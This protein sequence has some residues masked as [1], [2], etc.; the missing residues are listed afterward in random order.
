MATTTP[1][2]YCAPPTSFGRLGLRNLRRGVL[3]ADLALLLVFCWLAHPSWQGGQV[4]AQSA[5]RRAVPAGAPAFDLR[6]TAVP[7]QEIRGGGPPKDGI[8]AITDPAMIEA[9]R[10]R[11]LRP[12]DRVIGMVLR[13]ERN[14]QEAR[15]YPIKILTQHEIV[16]DRIGDT[17]IGV[18]YCPLCDSVAAFDRRTPL[19]EREFGVSG[20]LYNSNVLMY[21]RGGRP[22]SLW[23]QMAARGVSGPGIRASLEPLPVELTTWEDWRSRHPKTL[24]MSERTGHAR[25]YDRNPYARYFAGPQLM[26]PVRPRSDALPAKS[27]VLGVWTEDSARAYPLSAFGRTERT[28]TQELDGRRFTLHFDPEARS[29]RV[30]KADEGIDW[31]YSFWFAWYAFRPETEVFGRGR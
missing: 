11:Y 18:T 1:K 26:F 13:N 27:R 14:E 31:M 12:D 24:V 9:Q 22:E 16:N 28:L 19:G 2:P 23:S 17:P 20:L 25:R 8:P 6:Q 30:V 21:D 7:R 5:T 10:A 15:A 29:L 4:H 3:V